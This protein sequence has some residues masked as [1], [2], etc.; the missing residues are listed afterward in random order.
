[1]SALTRYIDAWVKADVDAITAIVAA[2]CVV[3]ECYGPVYRGR[4]SV[5]RWAHQWF[6]VGGVVHRWEVTDLV[7]A[8]DREVAQW[9]F[10]C[11]WM[12][13]RSTFEGASVARIAADEVV[14]LRE[15]QTTA[16]LYDWDGT[17]R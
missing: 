7:I 17:W 11:T 9:V 6:S 14:E 15:Y 10:E 16:A 2:D 1:M 8:G 4:D 3:T 12:G 13:N 5:R